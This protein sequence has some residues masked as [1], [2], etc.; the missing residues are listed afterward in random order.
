MEAKLKNHSWRLYGRQLYTLFPLLYLVLTATVVFVVQ[1][2]GI[3]PSGVDTLCHIYKGEVLYKAISEGNWWPT[4]DPMWYNGVEMLRYWAPL[5]V[6]LIAL[7]QW[8]CGGDPFY[9]Y[10]VLLGALCFLGAIVWLWIGQKLDR[11]CL[12][13]VI[14]GLWF[15]VPANLETFFAEGNLPRSICLVILPLLFYHIYNYSVNRRWQTLPSIALLF[16]CAAL[17][18]SGY[19]GM[20]LIALLI[21]LVFSYFCDREHTRALSQAFLMA[22]LGY[23]IIGIWLVPSL[24]G[25]ITST[26]S[27]EVMQDFFQDFIHITINPFYRYVAIGAFYYGLSFFV[28]GLFGFLTSPRRSKPGFIAGI[29][30]AFLTADTAYLLLAHVPGGQYLWMLRF[31]PIATCFV[32][33]SFLLWKELKKGLVIVFCLLIMLDIIPSLPL[34]S[35]NLSG[36]TAKQRITEMKK[37]TLSDKAREISHQRVSLVDESALDAMSPYLLT[38]GKNAVAITQGAAWQSATTAENFKQIDR[39]LEKGNYLYVFDRCLELGND[40]VLIRVPIVKNLD[41]HPLSDMDAAAEIFGYNLVEEN[42]RYRLYHCETGAENWGT[43][44]RYPAIGI[45]SAAAS[46]SLD[47]PALE[48]TTSTNL[49]DY[50]FEELSKYQLIYLAGFTYTDRAQA[51]DLILRLSEAGVKIVIAADGIP[52][53]RSTHDQSFLG[54]RCNP[55]E[56]HNGYPELDTVDGRLNVDLFPPEYEN[57][58]TVFLTGLDDVWGS[59]HDNG[60]KLDFYGTVRNE[61]IVVIGINLTRFYGLTND[62]NVEKL[63]SR[64]MTVSSRDLPERRIVP[65]TILNEP[66]R[67]TVVSKENHVNTSLAFH[68]SFVSSQPILEKNHLTYVEKGTTV[69]DIV[70]PYFVPGLCVSALGALLA[71]LFT[72][73]RALAQKREKQLEERE[74]KNET[75]IDNAPE[76]SE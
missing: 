33:L 39:A 69:I 64:A 60:L 4:Y 53:D 1:R 44:S 18:H 58:E 35:G 42:D 74:K 47:F 25:G 49:N 45:G 3:Y 51:E 68:D 34:L 67:V 59:L 26:D 38:A 12:G 70:T 61:N 72:L 24:V 50:S 63:L 52:E 36:V 21:L 9:G 16:A 15:F 48:E 22:A 5:P 13:G 55:V 57:W 75:C 20:I 19:A 17:C 73:R 40:S 43:V 37:E 65:L 31:L 10:L 46:I 7:C 29:C 2:S 41:A 27:T 71:V 23:A 62:Q 56:F 76:H 11:P 28:L 54:V 66:N 8:V 6:Y 30:I 32:I 14:G